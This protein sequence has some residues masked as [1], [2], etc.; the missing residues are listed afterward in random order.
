MDD[1]LRQFLAT[2]SIHQFSNC[3]KFVFAPAS[4]RLPRIL[5]IVRMLYQNVAIPLFAIV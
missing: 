5:A 1:K 3:K 4:G 2:S